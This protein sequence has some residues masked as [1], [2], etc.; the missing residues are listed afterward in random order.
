MLCCRFYCRLYI[1][2]IKVLYSCGCISLLF[3]PQVPL[4]FFFNAMIWLLFLMDIWWF[5]FIV[6]LII[7]IAVGKSSGVEDTREIPKDSVKGEEHGEVANG[8]V[9]QNGG[10]HNCASHIEATHTKGLC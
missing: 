8:K 6:L 4:Y 7:R 9:L 3:L 10:L 5:H 1:F 2:P